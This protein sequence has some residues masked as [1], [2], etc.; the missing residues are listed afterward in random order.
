MIKRV[1]NFSGGV[2]S[3]WAS[4]RVI[5]K[6]GP[7]NVILLFADTLRE[8]KE[9]HRFSS[10]VSKYF[11]IDITRV[12]S[13]KSVWGTCFKE[14]MIANSRVPICSIRLK[15][16]VLDKW[17]RENCDP[18]STV[19]YF[20]MDWNEQHRLD[21]LRIRYPD[22]VCEAP[23]LDAPFWDKDMMI[24]EIVKLG[25]TPSKQYEIGFSHDNCGGRCFASGQANWALALKT[26]RDGF[27]EDERMEQLFRLEFGDYSILKDRRGGVTKPMTLE[28]FR[29]RIERG[30]LYDKFDFGG[31]GC[32]VDLGE[33]PLAG[34]W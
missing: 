21:A 3:F 7:E 30:D 25:I 31:C 32:S 6:F 1:I 26:D 9:L 29:E 22:W 34:I 33:D 11:G 10:E 14:H 24:S 5:E 17:T 18:K 19:L 8:S 28:S 12:S 27:L 2:C 4:H 16:E 23:M 20:G 13:E 15:R